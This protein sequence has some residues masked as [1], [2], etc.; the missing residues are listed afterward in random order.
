M[1]SALC[2]QPCPVDH[3]GIW[4]CGRNFHQ[5]SKIWTQPSEP[6]RQ[7]VHCGTRRNTVQCTHAF[8][9]GKFPLLHADA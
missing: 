5:P 1:T 4:G 6:H 3:G 8:W 2:P 9:E 7:V